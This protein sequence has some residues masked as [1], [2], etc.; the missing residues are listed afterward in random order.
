MLAKKF[1]LPVQKFSASFPD[2]AA[3]GKRNKYF[4]LKARENGLG[5]GR[6]GV[7]I[8]KKVSK[9]AVARNA[10]KRAVFNSIKAEKIN[11]KE[12]GD[13][14]IIVLPPAGQLGKLSIKKELI[15][16]IKEIKF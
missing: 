1:K 14:L 3:Q 6:F 12:T 9:S 15:P 7:V 8:G 16:L 11:E 13:F 4:I 2:G 10:I 5:R